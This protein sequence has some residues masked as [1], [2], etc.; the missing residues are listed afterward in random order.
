MNRNL[1]YPP[2]SGHEHTKV[3]PVTHETLGNVEAR[4]LKLEHAKICWNAKKSESLVVL[5]ELVAIIRRKLFA[6]ILG[7]F[8]PSAL[9]GP[10]SFLQIK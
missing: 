4:K 8:L 9:S 10:A 3:W 6:I 2:T 5:G 7:K 1:V